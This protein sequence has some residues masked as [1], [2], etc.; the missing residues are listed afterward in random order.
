[1]GEGDQPGGPCVWGIYEPGRRPLSPPQNSM[2]GPMDGLLGKEEGTWP[3]LKVP[4][5]SPRAL[6]RP[7]S[8]S[9]GYSQPPLWHPS[10]QGD[11]LKPEIRHGICPVTLKSAIV[12]Y[13]F[14]GC[15]PTFKGV[16]AW[17]PQQGH[18]VPYSSRSP[19]SPLLNRYTMMFWPR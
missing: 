1:M 2:S 3:S 7:C 15:S 9:P 18:P 19:H 11:V 10:I 4:S 17:N 12:L 5:S 8:L 13:S 6:G 14:R 16:L